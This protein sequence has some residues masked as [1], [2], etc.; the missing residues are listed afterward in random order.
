MYSYPNNLFTDD[1][2]K[3]SNLNC[4][5]HWFTPVVSWLTNYRYDFYLWL[6]SF[7]LSIFRSRII[8]LAS[9]SLSLLALIV[10][11]PKP[12][13]TSKQ[14]RTTIWEE[15]FMIEFQLPV[16]HLLYLHNNNSHPKDE[17]Q[18]PM[19]IPVVKRDLEILNPT[20]EITGDQSRMKLAERNLDLFLSCVTA[21]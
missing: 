2:E 20:Q 8:N 12:K 4:S 11:F 16:H 19:L 3:E 7:W 15:S 13:L 1:L 18:I 5:F 6:Y 21:T 10:G 9:F 17:L 14:K